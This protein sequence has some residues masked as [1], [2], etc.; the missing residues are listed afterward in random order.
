[1]K[2]PIL[3]GLLIVFA[4]P[5]LGYI[6][7]FIMLILIA[8]GD[9]K[10]SWSSFPQGILT[11]LKLVYISY[12]AGG[13]QAVIAGLTVYYLLLKHKWISITS[14]SILTFILACAP[15]IF[16]ALIDSISRNSTDIKSLFIVGL[17]FAFSTWLAS[18]LLRKI[19]ISLQWMVPPPVTSKS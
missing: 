8:I 19:I 17:I 15:S 7:V 10:L 11:L 1:M 13:V 3:A 14:W 18:W 4:G 5:P 16:M 9:P 6:V 2:K 12:I